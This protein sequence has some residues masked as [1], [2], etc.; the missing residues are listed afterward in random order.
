MQEQKKILY[1]SPNGFLGGAERFVCDALTGHKNEGHENRDVLFFSK[2]DAYNRCL[3]SDIKTHL[4]P[5]SFKLSHPI[6][7]LKVVLWLRN[8]T[9]KNNYQVIHSTMP[10]AH[11]VASLATLFLPIKRVWF[12][13]GPVGGKLDKIANLLPVNKILFNSIYL[14]NEHL[15]MSL[16]S[17]NKQKHQIISLGTNEVQRNIDAVKSVQDKYKKNKLLLL[18]AGRLCSW[19]GQDK[20]IEALAIIKK[21]NPEILSKIQLIIVGDITRDSDKPYKSKLISL[22]EKHSLNDTISFV[23]HVNNIS[24][25]YQASDLFIHSSNIPE[26]FGLTVLEAMKNE[27]FVIGSSE[28][29]ISDLLKDNT[30]GLTYNTL[31]SNPNIAKDLA[32]KLQQYLSLDNNKKEKIIKNAKEHVDQ[33]YSIK[34]MIQQLEKVYS[35]I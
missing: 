6:K 29:G 33:N 7:L 20:V 10:Y 23:G 12:Q 2:G 19:K 5:I 26:P 34:N 14:E 4:L 24:D 17:R 21:S 18:S 22:V 30:T 28:G 32:D 31:L 9:K 15:K 13:H 27:T 25:Y 3:D 1:I 16:A 35:T 11:I 8:F